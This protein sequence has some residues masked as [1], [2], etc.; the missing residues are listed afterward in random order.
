MKSFLTLKDFFIRNKWSYIL[1]VIWLILTDSLQLVV[2]QILKRFTDSLRDQ[3]LSFHDLMRYIAM[4]MAIALTLAFFRYL[5]R[6]YIMGTSRSLEFELRNRL[7]THLQKLSPSYYN[8]QKTGDLM[9]HATNDISAV[10]M[11]M[12]PGIV[13]LTDSIFI[14]TA[15]VIILFKTIDVRLSLL[16]LFPLPFMVFFVTKVGTIIHNKFK[17][18]QESFSNLTDRVQENISGIRV[19]KTFIQEDKEILKFSET[20]KENMN[21]NLELIRLWGLFFPM[22]QFISGLSFF[23]LLVYGGTLVIYGDIS[24]GD[25]V[26]FNA[27]LGL[28]TWPIMAM[29]WVLNM[30]QRGAASMERINAIL[31]KQPEISDSTEVNENISLTGGITIKNLDFKYKTDGPLVLKNINISIDAG[32]TAAI[33]GHTGSGKSTLVNLLLRLYNVPRGSILID[34]IDIN[35]IPIK[36]LREHVGYVPQDN[37]LFSASISENISFA[38]E[39]NKLEEIESAAKVAQIYENV[40]EFPDS[41]ETI[42]GERGVTLS[43]G[44]KQRIAIARAII[45]NPKIL[46]LDDSFSAVD[47]YT[48]EGILNALKDIMASRTTLIISHRV[49]TVKNADIIYVFEKGTIIE[50]GTHDELLEFESHYYHLHQKQLLE[51]VLEGDREVDLS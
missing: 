6:I 30:L 4:L 41:F 38:F 9:A 2:P 29:G 35:D 10:R 24:L 14:S 26:A 16:A 45:K 3:T 28:L 12:G 7:F 37:F 51:D 21:R 15:T 47:T 36:T 5:W 20:A 43:G 48:E 22:I 17:R 40:K 32:K 23:A 19:I 50:R 18:V 46:I 33:I 11:A 42:I 8:Q 13:L 31:E 1:G 25:F 27:Y 39:N 49:S 44:Q 34:H